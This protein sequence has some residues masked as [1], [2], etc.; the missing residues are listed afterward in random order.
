MN[1]GDVSRKGD[2]PAPISPYLALMV[3]VVG[4]S[5]SSIFIRWSDSDPLVIAFYRM[6]LT[7]LILLPLAVRHPGLRSVDRPQIGLMFAVGAILA[8]HL[9]FFITSITLT[10]VANAIFLTNAHPLIVGVLSFILYREGGRHTALGIAL[11]FVGISLITA[12]GLGQS[13]E[14][15]VLGMLAGTMTAIYIL[16]GRRIR[17]AID[18]IPYAFMMYSFSALCLL[19]MVLVTG[20]PLYPYP[21]EEVAIF[22]A[23]AIVSTIFGHTLFNWSLKYVSASL[24]SLV[25]GDGHGYDLGGHSSLRAPDGGVRNGWNDDS[26]RN[27]RRGQDGGRSQRW[28]EARS[29][30]VISPSL[31]LLMASMVSLAP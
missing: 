6:A 15:D 7:S 13:S 12:G 11:G 28:N 25:R 16:L 5:F 29:F 24:V 2:H 3:A 10:S 27:T 21:L 20:A 9:A 30:T 8:F 22:L 1:I 31:A 17:M 4:V 14:G 18:I 19:I 23:L 26:D